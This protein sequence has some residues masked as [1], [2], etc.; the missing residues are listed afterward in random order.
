MDSSLSSTANVNAS[1]SPKSN[2]SESKLKSLVS[3]IFLTVSHP[4][5]SDSLILLD[6]GKLESIFNSAKTASGMIT[7]ENSFLSF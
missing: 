3:E 1:D 5:L 6:P 4:F 7:C 2:C